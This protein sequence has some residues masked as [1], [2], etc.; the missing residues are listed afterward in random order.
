M[1]VE[2]MDVV[3]YGCVVLPVVHFIELAYK[4]KSFASL[5]LG[6]ITI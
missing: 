5:V 6:F 2:R 3:G 1:R 4:C